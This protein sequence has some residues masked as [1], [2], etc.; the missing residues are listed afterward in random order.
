MSTLFC[1]NSLAV[2][3]RHHDAGRA[4]LGWANT[5]PVI[6]RPQGE[7]GHSRSGIAGHPSSRPVGAVDAAGSSR[8]MTRDEAAEL[9][10]KDV[11][12]RERVRTMLYET[13]LALTS[14]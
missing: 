5:T 3:I 1:L 11:P 14:C 9:L 8:A 6:I 2:L 12:L 13:A 4:V 7:L 10:A